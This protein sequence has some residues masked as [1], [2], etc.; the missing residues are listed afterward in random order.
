MRS[1]LAPSRE[2]VS[3]PRRMVRLLLLTTL[4]ACTAPPPDVFTGTW[5]ECAD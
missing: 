3:P 2:A 1:M 5:A 4:A